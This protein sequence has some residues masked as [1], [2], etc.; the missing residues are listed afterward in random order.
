MR[1][2]KRICVVTGG[3]SGIGLATVRRFSAV[4]NVTVALDLKPSID[5][6]SA[7]HFQQLDVSRP[8]DV[9]A[10]ISGLLRDY[11]Q[12]D[13]LVNAAGIGMPLVPVQDLDPAE[14]NR[15]LGI[16]LTGTFSTVQAVLPSML[17]R[18]SGSIVNV[19]STFGLLA[20]RYQSAYS[21]S[22]A[23]VIH[24]TR[25]IAVDLGETAIRVNCVCPGLTDTPLVSFF[26]EPANRELLAENLALHAMN[27]IGRPEEVAN[28]IAFLASESATFITGQAIAVDGGYTAGKWFE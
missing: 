5:P 27:R 6:G 18:N 1:E 25:C 2:A 8:D 22:K 11:G 10:C 3:S 28:A 12:I 9:R 7:A 17:Q 14:W 24:L 19:G 23:A 20:R 13:V 16:N 26:Q 4:G 15:I 21:V